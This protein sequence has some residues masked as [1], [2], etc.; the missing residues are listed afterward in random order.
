MLHAPS[1]DEPTA[2]RFPNN[3]R[4]TGCN[5]G[6][7]RSG[8]AGGFASIIYTRSKRELSI[9]QRRQTAAKDLIVTT[10]HDWRDSREG[11]KS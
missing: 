1:I 10:R 8:N 6:E 4:G 3:H 11:R 7:I 5:Y 9:F 2:V